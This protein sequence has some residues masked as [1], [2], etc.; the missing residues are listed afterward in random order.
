[1]SHKTNGL[2]KAENEKFALEKRFAAAERAELQ[3][4]LEEAQ[5]ELRF[6]CQ[7]V[8][9]GVSREVYVG[10]DDRAEPRA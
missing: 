3:S 1:L 6:A 9:P 4:A 7:T 10:V 8:D 5:D 2:L